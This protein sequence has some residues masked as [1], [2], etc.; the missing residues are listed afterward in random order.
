MFECERLERLED[1]FTGF[2][3]RPSK[4]VYFYRIN[5]YS[6]QIRRFLIRYYQEARRSGVV[7]EG[8]IP[9][10]TE[11]NLSYYQEMMGMDFQMSPGFLSQSLQ[12]W[13]PRMNSQ[14]RQS[15]ATSIYDVLDEMRRGGKNENM[16]KNAY[17]KFM[18]WL[19]YKFERV[20]NR[21]GED[22]LP[23]ILYEADV[24]N[25]ELKFLSVLSKAGCDVVLLQ[26][27][28]DDNYRRLDPQSK[29]S[30]PYVEPGQ[31]PFPEGFCLKRLREEIGREQKIQQLYRG[32]PGRVNCTNAWISGKGFADV[33]QSVGAR[34][35]DERFFYNAFIRMEG[36]E[37]KL[38]Y[39]NELLQFQQQMKSAGR[40]L[41][42][43]EKKIPAPDPEEI[44]Q[45]RRGNYGSVEQLLAGLSGNIQY[46]ASPE[47]QSLMVKAFVD[48]VLEEGARQTNLHRLTNQAVYL[49][50]WLRRYQKLLFANWKPPQI[51]CLV[52][53]GGCGSPQ[54]ALFLRMMARL[55]V[56]VLVLEPNL[57]Q[58]GVLEDSQ[59]Y[60]I[61]FGES[62]SIDEFPAE[63]GGE[64]RA[65]TAAYHAERELDTL[66]YQDS[67]IY[68]SMQYEKETSISLQTTYEEIRI[69]WNQEVK[70]RPN[71]SVVGG[72]VNLPVIFAK[73]S[74]VKNG[75][76]SQY[77][78]SVRALITED[79]LVVR[80]NPMVRELEVN[81]VKPHATEFFKNRRLNRQKIKSHPSYRYGVLREGMQELILDKLQLLIEQ[82]LIKGTF[83]NG[84]E[85]TIVSTVL[86]MGKDLIRILQKFDLTQRNPKLI[87]INTTE[88]ML[89]LEESIL[90]A[91]LNL[92]GFDIVF[93]I[94]TGYQNVERYFN[95]RLLEEH[96]I[97]E[98]LYDLSIPDL[99]AERFGSR[100]SLL[101]K[102]F[103]RNTR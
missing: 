102:L 91:F 95:K 65:G 28:G 13:L 41:L 67:G 60:E 100:R 32:E 99:D 26:Y 83:E 24:S 87:Y 92:M 77:W 1:F 44:G 51:G 85:Y 33:L 38:T 78:A 10:P 12:K 20:V 98:Y 23:K 75:E 68:R 42:I 22:N 69:L 4:G 70:Y 7:L 56:D 57:N 47:L 80:N 9:N 8:R 79:T 55:P 86:N 93:F 101:G 49:L 59:L 66:M 53:L 81:P 63:S 25:Y 6:E 73:V 30:V 29:A 45:I 36:V 18:C 34:G 82:R 5:G 3:A 40:K 48:V 84:T 61:H 64:I 88:R 16:L 50:C 31:Q 46:A 72:T 58:T 90:V 94:P 62:L 35:D 21:L 43:L 54:E 15:V 11:D 103:G 89:N 97:G 96:Q 14:Q 71:F 37:D 19:Y 39:V 52:Y 74:G 17:I 2:A 27:R 76:V